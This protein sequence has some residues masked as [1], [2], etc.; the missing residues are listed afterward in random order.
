MN[1]DFKEL[2]IMIG[3]WRYP[4]SEND[5]KQNVSLRCNWIMMGDWL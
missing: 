1:N 3:D 5:G 2:I 4:W